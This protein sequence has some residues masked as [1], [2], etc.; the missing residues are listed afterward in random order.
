MNFANYKV[1]VVGS[2]LYGATLA[3]RLAEDAKVPVLILDRRPHIGGNSWSE[4]DTKTGIEF[5]KYGSHL[6]H[7][8]SV[9]VWDYVRRFSEFTSYRHRVKTLHKGRVFSMPINLDTI[10]SFYGK[11]VC[12]SEAL[13]LIN[14]EIAKESDILPN[15]LEDKAILSIGRPLYEAFIKGYT[16]KQWQTQPNLLP[17][18][19]IGRLP[20]RFNFDDRYFSDRFE[21]LPTNGYADLITRMLSN[22][23]IDV[24]TSTDYFDIKDHF[25]D[26][27]L[28]I[29]TG[30]IDRYFDYRCGRLNWRTLDFEFETIEQPDFQGTSVMNYADEN[31]D[32]TRIH[33]FQHLHP[34]RVNLSG[35]TLIAKEYS[36]F[37]GNN[38]EP[39]YP[40]GT[41]SDQVIYGMYKTMAQGRP[42]VI[43]GGRLGTY[44]YLD[45]HQAIGAALKCYSSRVIPFLRN[46]IVSAEVGSI[47]E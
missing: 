3:E 47:D 29:Y 21:G 24:L 2:G 7:T 33:E 43:F 6:F 38:D 1:V 5:H 41:R 11:Y 13:N 14:A 28:I 26:D 4:V 23:K 37:A 19:I 36:R 15:S 27:Q 40:I 8:N 10:S 25:S 39:Y 18:E 16:A 17:P 44:R 30:P 35:K 9:S 12:P 22:K 34:E 32:Y 45:M 20:V 31:V 46:G 42:N